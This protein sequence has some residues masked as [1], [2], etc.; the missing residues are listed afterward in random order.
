MKTKKIIIK[1]REEFNSEAM[2]FAS[3]IDRGES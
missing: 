3:R 2:E 1:L